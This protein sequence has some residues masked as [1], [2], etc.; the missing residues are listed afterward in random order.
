MIIDH[1]LTQ[2]SSEW[3]RA[4]L[5]VLTASRADKLITPK[6]MQLSSQ[7]DDLINQL[8]YEQITNEPSDDFGGSYYTERGQM[9]EGEAL[10]YFTLQTGLVVRSAGLVYKDVTKEAGCSPDGLVYEPNAP[11]DEPTA[12]LELKCPKDKTA[13]AYL[14]ASGTDKYTPQVQFSLWVTGLPYWY[15]M[16]YH[17][18]LPPVLQVVT[19]DPKWQTAFDEHVPDLLYT[20]RSERHRIEAMSK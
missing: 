13:I 11:Q 16:S 6:K 18:L 17:P 8:L 2:G 5:G 19:K 4:R 20:L 3:I 14:R 10:A 15:F 1:A 7:S 9:L 12:G